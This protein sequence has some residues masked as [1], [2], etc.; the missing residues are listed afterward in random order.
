M[1][2]YMLHFFC[3]GKGGRPN[4]LCATVV[5]TIGVLES[6]KAAAEVYSPVG[7]QITAINESLQSEPELVNKEPYG[8]GQ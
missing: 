3:I 7:G 4:Y 2:I 1:C 6:V 8:K 5:D